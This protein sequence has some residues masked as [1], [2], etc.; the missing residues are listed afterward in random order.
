LYAILECL[1]E[2][3]VER[4][5][6]LDP[7]FRDLDHMKVIILVLLLIVK[8]YSCFALIDVVIYKCY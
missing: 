8:T 6:C 1:K 2:T 4:L 5:F 3:A 7:R